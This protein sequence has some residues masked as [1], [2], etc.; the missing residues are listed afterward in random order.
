MNEEEFAS[1]Q[2]QKSRTW[3]AYR[4]RLACARYIVSHYAK[5][6]EI[7]NALNVSRRRFFEVCQEIRSECALKPHSL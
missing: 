2:H 6:D 4:L 7:C 1:E 3:K 5:P